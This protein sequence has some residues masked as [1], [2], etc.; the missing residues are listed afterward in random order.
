MCTSGFMG[1]LLGGAGKFIQTR[2]S[3]IEAARAGQVLPYLLCPCAHLPPSFP[4]P[5]PCHSNFV[6]QVWSFYL[7]HCTC[8]APLIRAGISKES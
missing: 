6:A 1:G 7:C 8:T 5:L 4:P 2:A 3:F